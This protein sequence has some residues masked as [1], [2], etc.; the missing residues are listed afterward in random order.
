MLSALGVFWVRVRTWAGPHFT[1]TATQTA[2][3]FRWWT[4]TLLVLFVY[5]TGPE[6]YRRAMQPPVVSVQC[7]DGKAPPCAAP[8]PKV[9]HDNPSAEDIAKAIAPIQK[10]LDEANKKIAVLTS[11]NNEPAPAPKPLSPDEVDL[12]KDLRTFARSNIDEIRDGIFRLNQ[13]VLTTYQQQGGSR[14][15]GP[16]FQQLMGYS[17]QTDIYKL[18]LI[19]AKPDNESTPDDIA[20]QIRHTLNSY[21]GWQN[22]VI[23]FEQ[24]SGNTANPDII[25]AL[26]NILKA[27]ERAYGKY[28]DLKGASLLAEKLLKGVDENVFASRNNFFSNFMAASGKK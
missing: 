20:S 25:Q 26:E 10:K 14:P 23:G 11:K 7:W 24:L 1:A 2:T 28:R 13:I 5:S 3:D 6:I 19:V 27:D 17:I 21:A 9:I 16:L 4:A 18:D 12:R 22:N 15:L 8:A